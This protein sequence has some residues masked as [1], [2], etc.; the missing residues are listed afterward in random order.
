MK[1]QELASCFKEKKDTLKLVSYY[2]KAD[3]V[4]PFITAFHPNR[5]VRDLPYKFRVRVFDHSADTLLA[6]FPKSKDRAF[7]EG[8]M[9]SLAITITVRDTLRFAYKTSISPIVRR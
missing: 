9:S 6:K 3:T 5:I 2:D 4:L 8:K 1:Y 7:E